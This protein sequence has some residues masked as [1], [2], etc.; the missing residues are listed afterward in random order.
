MTFYLIGLGLTEEHISFKA[1]KTLKKCKTIYLEQYTSRGINL[2]NLQKIINKKIQLVDRT[3]IESSKFLKQAKT[4]NIALLIIG[5]VFSATTHID[6]FLQAKKSKIKTE[7]IDNLSILTA[8][9]ITG[10]SL[11]KFGAT[12]SIPYQDVKSFY[13]IYKK[14]KKL[15]LHTLFLLD[16]KENETMSIKQALTKLISLGLKNNEKIVVCSGIQQ[17]Q[18]Q[19]KF[20]T[21]KKLLN[22]KFKNQL[23]C[24]IIPGNLHFM[25]EEVLDLYKL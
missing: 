25:E 3:F 17:K 8:I 5:G 2:K 4:N 24:I 14:N 18:Q 7:I 15:N 11:Y 12:A 19:I 1:I 6:L 10:L 13:E 9:S 22:F 21:V 23:S 20:S 16:L